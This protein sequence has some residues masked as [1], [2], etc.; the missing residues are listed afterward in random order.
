MHAC[1]SVMY[2]LF[3]IQLGFC[4]CFVGVFCCQ[5]CFRALFFSLFSTLVVF[6]TSCAQCTFQATAPR[7]SEWDAG[8]EEEVKG[9]GRDL[10]VSAAKAQLHPVHVQSNDVSMSGLR[11]K[12][13]SQTAICPTHDNRSGVDGPNFGQLTRTPSDRTTL[14]LIEEMTAKAKVEERQLNRTAGVAAGQAN[15]GDVGR[16][17]QV[18]QPI[19]ASLAQLAAE[20]GALPEMVVLSEVKLRLADMLGKQ[21]PRLTASFQ[22]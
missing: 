7:P 9:F 13:T 6:P 12:T 10:R 22:P 1:P 17:D 5:I 20:K 11:G 8:K 4:I 2:N 21:N 18:P 3:T 19:R 14:R 15:D 16:T